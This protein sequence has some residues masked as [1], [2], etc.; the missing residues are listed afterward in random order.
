MTTCPATRAVPPPRRTTLYAA[1]ALGIPVINVYDFNRRKAYTQV[2]NRR[3]TGEAC[4][5]EQIQ[6]VT[7]R[8]YIAQLQK[9]GLP[10]PPGLETP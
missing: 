10:V 6:H 4:P 5:G 1:F 8:F 7:I 2:E 3:A 9:H